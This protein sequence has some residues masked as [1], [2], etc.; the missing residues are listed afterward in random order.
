MII[1]PPSK[2]HPSGKTRFRIDV[3]HKGKRHNK[4]IGDS[5]TLKIE[6][7]R[8]IAAEAIANLKNGKRC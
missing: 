5:T 2:K 8:E 1:S 6:D 4:L 3:W 7:A